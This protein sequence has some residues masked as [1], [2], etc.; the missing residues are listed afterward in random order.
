MNAFI[1]AKPERGFRRCGV[2]FPRVGETFEPDD[3]TADQWAVLNAEPNLIVRAAGAEGENANETP[4]DDASIKA[5]MTAQLAA[6]LA[7]DFQKNGKPKL[8][9]FQAALPEMKKHITGA[10]R[11]AVWEAALAAGFKAPV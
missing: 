2:H 6:F 5:A 1:R 8:E 4:P 7:A 3:F 10:L 9:A 11:D